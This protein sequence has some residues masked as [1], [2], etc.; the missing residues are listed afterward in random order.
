MYVYVDTMYV[1]MQFKYVFKW[2]CSIYSQIY[3]IQGALKQYCA[4][5]SNS[6]GSQVVSKWLHSTVAAPEQAGKVG[7]AWTSRQNMCCAW[8]SRQTN[9]AP[10][11]AGKI[12]AAPEQSGQC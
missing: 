3:L 7:S 4:V 6:Q 1:V 5:R 2:S 8:T 9:A 10:E 11:Q 12:Y